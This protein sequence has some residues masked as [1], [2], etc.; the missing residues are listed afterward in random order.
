MRGW[1]RRL[2]AG[3]RWKHG[4]ADN[5]GPERRSLNTN[6]VVCGRT[7]VEG[8]W[9]TLDKVTYLEPILTSKLSW[10]S[11]NA[12]TLPCPST[13]KSF[14]DGWQKTGFATRNPLIFSG[15]NRCSRRQNQF[16]TSQTVT[17]LIISL[18]MRS[19]LIQCECSAVE[20]RWDQKNLRVWAQF[21]AKAQDRNKPAKAKLRV[22]S[23]SGR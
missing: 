23:T 3:W 20:N 12:K 21:R 14:G 6:S 16:G 17:R 4:Y 19:E 8:S 9:W 1:T 5:G 2:R 13:R 18:G 7:M 22:L 15:E 11:V 10:L